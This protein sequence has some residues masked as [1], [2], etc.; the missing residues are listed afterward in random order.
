MAQVPWER[1]G[2]GTRAALEIQ[3]GRAMPCQAS[4]DPACATCGGLG[5]IANLRTR[6]GMALPHEPSKFRFWEN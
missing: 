4:F 6:Q 5:L 1:K 3:W 2:R